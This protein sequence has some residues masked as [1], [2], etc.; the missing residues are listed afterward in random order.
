MREGERNEE[1]EGR[2]EGG[3]ERERKG[4]KETANPCKHGLSM[5]KTSQ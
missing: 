4:E 1:R 3:G 2:R 5:M